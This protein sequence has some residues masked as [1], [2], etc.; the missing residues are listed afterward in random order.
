MIKLA[1]AASSVGYWTVS[2]ISDDQ[3]TVSLRGE[4]IYTTDT[5]ESAI[6]WLMRKLTCL[7]S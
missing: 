7:D 2:R 4:V 3:V 6:D 5:V 1:G